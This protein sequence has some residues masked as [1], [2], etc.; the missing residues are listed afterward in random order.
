[1]PSVDRVA[2][3]PF[4]CYVLFLQKPYEMSAMVCFA[5]K[6][7]E[8]SQVK[9]TTLKYTV[10]DVWSWGLNVGDARLMLEPSSVPQNSHC[11]G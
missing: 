7:V 10:N 3:V 9:V 8:K 6:A 2:V 1:M 5:D 11:L 4:C